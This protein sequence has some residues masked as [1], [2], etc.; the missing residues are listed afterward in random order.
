ME[1]NSVIRPLR[2]AQESIGVEVTAVKCDAQGRLDP[3][4]VHRALGPNT[5][6]I[7]ITHASNVSGT[8][9]PVA[10]V[11][12]IAR[13][14][15]VFMVVDAAQTAGAVDIDLRALAVDAL[16][17]TGHKGLYGPPGTGGMVLSPRAAAE[18]APLIQGG[19]GSRSDEEFQPRFVP[20]K[21]E[22]GTPNTLGIAGLGAGIRFV[23]K[24]EV[25]HIGMHELRLAGEFAQAARAITGIRVFGP[26]ETQASASVCA[27][28]RVAT[29]SVGF[30]STQADASRVAFL[31]DRDFGIM[32]RSGLHCAPAA[33][34]TLGTFPAGTLRF[35][36]GW[37]NT[38]SDAHDA[39]SALAQI[40]A[41]Y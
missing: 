34:R 2:S 11:A 9:M 15:G 37:F 13:E 21:F 23:L 27:R 4:D 31:L 32:V 17:F 39:A 35:S 18:M 40:A 33:H 7:V 38:M 8:V 12:G 19:T 3:R 24:N 6:M 28:D 14:A 10:E 29:V 5:R 22:P 20:D 25:N 1:H 30:T 36:F 41:G 26:W 16:A